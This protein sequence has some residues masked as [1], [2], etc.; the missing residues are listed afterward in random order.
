MPESGTASSCSPEHT[1]PSRGQLPEGFRGPPVPTA[2]RLGLQTGGYTRLGRQCAILTSRLLAQPSE[3]RLLDRDGDG[4]ISDEVTKAGTPGPMLHT[5][6]RRPTTQASAC[7]TSRRPDRVD[8][9]PE[10]FGPRRSQRIR[11]VEELPRV[12]A[13]CIV[14]LSPHDPQRASNI[15][16]AMIHRDL[17]ANG[18]EVSAVRVAFHRRIPVMLT[19]RR[20]WQDPVR[21]AHGCV[22]ATAGGHHQLPRRP[23]SSDLVGRFMVTVV[24]SCGLTGRSPEQ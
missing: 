1:T 8:P 9:L 6:S 22:V 23:H 3:R 17:L 21:R 20:L 14:S 11:R 12:L 13:T 4:L 24:T 7:T 18:N 19:V 5:R 10:V 15:R 2:E 16:A